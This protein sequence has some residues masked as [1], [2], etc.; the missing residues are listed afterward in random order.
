MDEAEALARECDVDA[1]DIFVESVAFGQRAPRRAWARSRASTRPAAARPRRAALDACARCRSRSS[2][3]ARS[4]DHLSLHAPGRRRAARGVRDRRRAAARR[5]ADERRGTSPPARALADA[6]AICVLATDLNPGTSPIASMPVIIGLAV[7]RYG[8]SVREALL[9]STL[10]AAYVLGWSRRARLARARQARRRDRCST[11]RP[12]TSPTA[13]GHNPVAAVF[14]GGELAWRAPRPGVAGARVIDGG[15]AARPARRARADRARREGVDAARVD[16]G[17]RRR[18]GV[19]RASRPRAAGLR[20]ERDPAGLAVGAART[21]PGRGGRPA[22]TSTACARGGRFDGAAR[23]RRGVR[24]RRARAGRRGDRL[25]R[26]GGR[27]LQHADVR[28]ARARPAGSTWPTCSR[29]ATTTA[30]RSPTRCARP[31]PTRTALADAPAWLARLRGFVELHIDQTRDLERLG[32]PAGAVRALAVAD[33]ARARRFTGRADHAGHDAP[34]RAPRRARRRRAAD[35]RRRRARRRRPATSSSPP[36]GSSSSRTRSRRCPA[37]VRLWIDAPHARPR[38]GSPRWR[39]ALA[40]RAGELAAATGVEIDARDRVAAPTASRSTA[41]VRAALGDLPEL[42]CFAGHDAGHPRRAHARPAWSSCA[43]R[44]ASATRPR[45]TSSSRTPPSRRPRCS[46]ALEAPRMTPYELPAMVNAHSH[47]FQRDLR[48]AAE[49]PAPEAHAADDFWS[50]REAMYRLAGEHDPD[51]M[52]DGRRA[53]L[54]RDGRRRL[55]RRRRVPL[56][57]PP[58]RRHAVPGP[59]R[60]GD[61]GRRGGASPPACAIVLLPAAYHRAGWDGPPTPGQRRFCDPDVGDLPRARR[62]AARLGGRA[63]DGV[64]RRRRRAQR[65]RRPGGWLEAIAAYA[66]AARARPPRPRPRAA[67][68]AARSAAPSTASRR[69]SCSHRTGFL[70]PRTSVI[71]GIHVDRRRTSA[72][73]P[74]SDTIVVSCPTTEGSLGDGHFPAL[75]YRDA[76]VRIAI[77]SDSQRPRRPVRGDARARDARAARAPHAPRAARRATATCGASSRRNGRASLGL[78]RRR[79]DRRRPRPPGPARASP[80]PT[81]RSPSRPAPRPPS[82]GR[83][84]SQPCRRRRLGVSR[85]PVA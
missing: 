25:R 60:D 21:T 38:R 83:D 14:A 33:A 23:R 74:T 77:G 35:R 55:R 64:A 2:C 28:L 80:T 17:A 67:A 53:R 18:R 40:A 78:E 41:A 71:H 43:T 20:V 27:A 32:A 59:E 62:R 10:N 70:G 7:R 5:R 37:G 76:G 8:W 3:G 11:A 9:A 46:R 73:S 44:P 54:R 65:P 4:V 57:P 12:S 68:R 19:V 42:V 56:R 49:R 61:R 47:A 66:D 45:S 1:L 50:W 34:R 24:R 29:A 16:G 30:S 63:R 13:S 6:G 36:R 26:R 39:E 84:R 81:S 85:R 22:R 58:A 51:S 72:G 79:D 52:R 82:S 15:R 69:S 75:V 31:A 48:G